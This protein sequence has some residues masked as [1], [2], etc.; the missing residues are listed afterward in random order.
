[1]KHYLVVSIGMIDPEVV[2]GPYDN[3]DELIEA[4]RK[5][6]ADEE[7]DLGE[8]GED[9]LFWLDINEEGGLPEMGSFSGG[10]MDEARGVE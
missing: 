5:L 3:N 4:A 9:A 1:V 6:V 8:E 2:A 7:F 10:F